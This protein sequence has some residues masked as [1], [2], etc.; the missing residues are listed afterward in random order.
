MYL[1]AFQMTELTSVRWCFVPFFS[2]V[3]WVSCFIVA[4]Y[5]YQKNQ[6]QK[7]VLCSGSRSQWRLVMICVPGGV[8]Y[9]ISCWPLRKFGHFCLDELSCY[10]RKLHCIN[11]GFLPET[12]FKCSGSKP[13]SSLKTKAKALILHETIR[14]IFM[15]SHQHVLLMGYN[16]ELWC[17][18]NLLSAR[19]FVPKKYHI[20]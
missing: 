15:R 6:T 20:S 4:E 10:C 17:T 14:R 2:L 11:C 16:A 5:L 7:N 1:S 3:E 19:G 9:R 8:H 12:S 13:Q 18:W